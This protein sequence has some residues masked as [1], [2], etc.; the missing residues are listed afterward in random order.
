MRILLRD[1]LAMPG[2]PRSPTN[3]KPGRRDSGTF[4][5]SAIRDELAKR[6]VPPRVV[7]ATGKPGGCGFAVIALGKL[8]GKELNYSSEYRF[9]VPLRLATARTAGP[10]RDHQQEF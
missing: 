4:A 9:D 1:V 7:V 5:F 3:H 8:G 10:E 2:F 6:T